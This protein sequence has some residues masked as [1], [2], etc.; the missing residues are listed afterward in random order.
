MC[1][2]QARPP[3]RALVPFYTGVAASAAPVNGAPGG[4]GDEPRT[5]IHRRKH[6]VLGGVDLEPGIAYHVLVY[7]QTWGTAVGTKSGMRLSDKEEEPVWRAHCIVC[8]P[9]AEPQSARGDVGTAEAAE[10]SARSPAA[11]CAGSKREPSMPA[12]A[13]K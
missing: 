12:A 5:V 9:N 13:T 2:V 3:R 11:A 10:A 7:V 4:D 1:V 6:A 8:R